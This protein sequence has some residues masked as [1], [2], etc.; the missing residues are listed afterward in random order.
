MSCILVVSHHTVTLYV[1]REVSGR[2]TFDFLFR[3][4]R[5]AVRTSLRFAERAL[6]SFLSASAS[7][8]VCRGEPDISPLI[9]LATTQAR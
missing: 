3:H 2:D 1:F 6:P 7:D 5:H 4:G 8:G 9:D